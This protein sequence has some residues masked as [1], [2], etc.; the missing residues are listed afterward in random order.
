MSKKC[1]ILIILFLKV[2]IMFLQPNNYYIFAEENTEITVE[3]DND[4]LG[5]LLEEKIEENEK[6]NEETSYI[7]VTD[8]DIADYKTNMEVG[9]KQLL[10]VTVLPLDATDKKS[11]ILLK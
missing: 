5:E 8:L 4:K 2:F 10:V 7:K 3:N 6:E 11:K 1:L 9:E